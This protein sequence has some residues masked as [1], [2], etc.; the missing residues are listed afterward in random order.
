MGLIWC[1]IPFMV[2]LSNIMK[3]MWPG[4]LLLINVFQQYKLCNKFWEKK[5]HMEHRKRL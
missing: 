4:K 2:S 1:M 3:N 5:N